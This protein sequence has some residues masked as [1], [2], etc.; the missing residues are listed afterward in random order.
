METAQVVLIC[1]LI[2]D[3]IFG[4]IKMVAVIK[5]HTLTLSIL[6]IIGITTT[7]SC[8]FTLNIRASVIGL[9]RNALL[10]WYHHLII[11]KENLVE[12]LRKNQQ[13]QRQE[14]NITQRLES[15]DLS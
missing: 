15:V 5:E 8:L 13:G 14:P 10:M 9:V 1:A 3:F 2:F 12:E 6:I 4:L 11:K 7:V